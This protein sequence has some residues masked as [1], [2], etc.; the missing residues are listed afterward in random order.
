MAVLG[1]E[2]VVMESQSTP[3]AAPGFTTETR[4]DEAA[5]APS[6]PAATGVGAVLKGGK[7][8]SEL[9]RPGVDVVETP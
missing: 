4:A 2:D 5:A 7:R 3:A 9:R 8:R 6:L 1:V